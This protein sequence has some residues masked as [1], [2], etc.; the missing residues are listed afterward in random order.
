MRRTLFTGK[1]NLKTVLLLQNDMILT[2]EDP[3]STMQHKKI[4][5]KFNLLKHVTYL[6]Y[7]LPHLHKVN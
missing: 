3:H 6:L 4:T 5:F 2:G 1:H 7:T